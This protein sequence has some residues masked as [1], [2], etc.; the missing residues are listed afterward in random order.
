[1]R[2]SCFVTFLSLAML[3]SASL[4]ADFPD[5]AQLPANPKLPDPLVMLDGRK[6]GTK[7]QW[8]TQRK[9][10]LKALFGHYMYGVRPESLRVESLKVVREDPRALKGKATL[11]EIDI[12]IAGQPEATIH[13]LLV[14]P[15]SS[16]GKVPTF[17]GANFFGNH[18]VLD[19]PAIAL[20]KGWVPDKVA[21]SMNNQATE[22]GREFQSAAWSIEQNIDRGYAV[23]TF[24][25]GDVAPDHPGFRDGVFTREER[26]K[27]NAHAWGAVSAWAWGIERAVDYLMTD[28][29]VDS[30]KIVVV[31]HS[32]LGKAAILAGALDDRIAIVTAHQAGCGGTAPS[33]GKI[34]ESVKQINERFPQWFCGEFQGFNNEPEKLPFDQNCLFALV[35]PRPLLLTNAVGDTWANPSGQFEALSAASPV[36]RLL[37][38]SGL[39]TESMPAVGTL[40]A[41]KLGYHIRPGKHSMLL[42][43]W[44][45]WWDYIER[46]FDSKS[47]AQ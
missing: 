7:E 37:G 6:V 3:N 31:G 46:Q 43:D 11:K 10:E 42:D 1:M 38:V 30:S 32:R 26:D 47:P 39:E 14:T 28:A 34:G 12:A 45:V 18:T 5:L 22:E 29:R 8:I 41:G 4:L 27:R 20:P 19:D 25:C 17:V 33:R 9:P 2:L 16:K 24:Y 44:K 21:K 23:A 13:L 40:S 15:N 35:A 36:Y